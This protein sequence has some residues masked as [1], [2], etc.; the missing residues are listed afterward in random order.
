MSL[1]SATNLGAATYLSDFGVLRT[2]TT[3][4]GSGGGRVVV[5]SA[6]HFPDTRA[7][8]NPTVPLRHHLRVSAAWAVQSQAAPRS[9]EQSRPRTNAL[10]VRTANARPHIPNA[11]I[12][13]DRLPGVRTPLPHVDVGVLFQVRRKFAWPS[14]RIAPGCQQLGRRKPRPGFPR[15]GVGGSSNPEI[16]CLGC[17]CCL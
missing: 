12:L 14:P 1:G 15:G 5:G 3:C 2:S 16:F 13:H 11:G 17:V 7:C 9:Q 4:S 8:L 10:G 6:P